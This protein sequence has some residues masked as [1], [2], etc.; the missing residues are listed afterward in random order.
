MAGTREQIIAT[1]IESVEK[2]EV[3]DE[4]LRLLGAAKEKVEADDP[5]GAAD[6]LEELLTGLG[7]WEVAQLIAEAKSEVNQGAEAA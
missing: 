6:T 3:R 5:S 2:G 7:G 4:A 1:V